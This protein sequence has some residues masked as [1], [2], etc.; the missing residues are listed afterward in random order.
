MKILISDKIDESAFS[1]FKDNKI[2]YDYSPEITLDE[3]KDK[4]DNYDALIVRS[5][6]KV[7][8]D[9]ID[10]G[11]NLKVIGRAG[12]GVD[13]IDVDTCKSKGIIVV[14]APDANSQAVAEHAV[15]LILSLLR[16]Y[17]KAFSSVREGLWLKKEL[18][19]S[20]L[21]GKTVGILGFGHIGKKVEKLVRAFGAHPLIFSKSYQTV[22]FKELFE[23][24]DIVS[25]HLSLN[26]DTKGCVIKWLLGLMKPSAILVNTSRGEI[27]DEKALY[28]ALVDKKI[29]GAA[30]DVYSQEPLPVDSPFR[31]LDNCLL[32]P[33][34]GAAT[35]EALKRASMT[36]AEDI[37]RVLKGKRPKLKLYKN[38]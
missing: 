3:L 24:S 10:K 36:V 5:R 19:G 35:K 18:G 25:V 16:H 8:K 7:T 2:D 9:I 14:N 31:K 12:M 29:A 38:N 20:E 6:T 37:V 34:I 13:N 22:E 28:K 30:L 23:K 26:K 4:I 33:H 15:G 32:T 1:L 21:C 17:P 27:V 11:K